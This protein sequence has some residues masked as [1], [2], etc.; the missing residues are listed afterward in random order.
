MSAKT[1]FS[2]RSFGSLFVSWVLITGIAVAVSQLA[3]LSIAWSVG[4]AIENNLGEASALIFLG[5]LLGVVM[6]GVAAT[7]QTLFLRGRVNAWRWIGGAAA[8][9]TLAMILGLTL[10]APGTE[11]Q[12]S[13]IAGLLAGGVLGLGIAAGQWLALRGRLSGLERW[14]LV[15]FFSYAVA[16]I[17]LFAAGG[18]GREAFALTAS[19][20]AFGVISGLGAR[21]AGLL[22]QE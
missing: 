3:A 2:S 9:A 1:L 14:A 4:E 5:V 11:S 21:W 13:W 15:C 6:G 22:E 8:G 10:I 20:L 12:P 18:E 7:S 19:G 16:F 17:L